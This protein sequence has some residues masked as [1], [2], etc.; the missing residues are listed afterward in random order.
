MKRFVFLQSP[1]LAERH[2]VLPSQRNTYQAS[3][4]GAAP[5]PPRFGWTRPRDLAEGKKPL[6]RR[7]QSGLQTTAGMTIG[8]E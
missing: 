4:C 5:E 8:K 7:C 2:A 6:C 3:L 1:S